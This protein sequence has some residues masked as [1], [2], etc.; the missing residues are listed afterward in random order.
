[1]LDLGDHL[2]DFLRKPRSRQVIILSFIE[3]WLYTWRYFKLF[4]CIYVTFATNLRRSYQYH[5]RFSHEKTEAKKDI[6][7]NLSA[8]TCCVVKPGFHFLISVRRK[9]LNH[10]T[11]CFVFAFLFWVFLCVFLLWIPLSVC[12]RLWIPSQNLSTCKKIRKITKT[13]ILTKSD[14]LIKKWICGIVICVLHY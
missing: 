1:M 11:T 14:Q 6:F 12:W 10:P 4:M 8:V 13:F 3:C 7:K 5:T 9:V 2:L